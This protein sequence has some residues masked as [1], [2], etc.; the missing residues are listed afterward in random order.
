MPSLADGEHLMTPSMIEIFVD[1]DWDEMNRVH[2]TA[3][4]FLL[5]QH[6]GP[7]T[8]N[9]C[10]MVVCELVENSLKYGCFRNKEEQVKASILLSP[11]Q[12]TVEVT[13]PSNIYIL[14][15]LREFDRTIQ[16]VRGFQDPFEA[17]MKRI[18][19]IS[20]EALTLD[21]SGLGIA[22]IAYE[23]RAAIDFIIDENYT[24]TVSAVIP[25]S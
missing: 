2:T 8:I 25:I 15:N 1:Q 12:V 3:E 9:R 23:G 19:A 21:K 14:G 13:N 7:E 18:K 24:L 17:Y 4:Q 5:K 20:H 16:W 22:R 10:A 6:F 11:S